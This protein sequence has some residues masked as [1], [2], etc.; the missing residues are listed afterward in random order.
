MKRVIVITSEVLGGGS[1]E[2]GAQLMDSLLRNLSALHGKPDAILFYNSG[3]RLLA[4]KSVALGA[5]DTLFRGG[6]DIIA[7]G[8]CVTYYQLGD[9]IA[10]GR[11]SN[12]QEIASILL[13]A[14]KLV[15]V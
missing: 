7:C 3:V 9:K 12:M 13:E 8:T 6:V 2:L 1:D 15:T 11:V 14:E 5:L 4:E 10:V